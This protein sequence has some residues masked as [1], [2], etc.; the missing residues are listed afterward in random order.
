M[1]GAQHTPGPWLAAE[2]VSS[3]VGLPVVRSG[4]K[5]GRLICNVNCVADPMHGKV[6]GDDAFN[7]EALANAKLIAAAPE[8][9]NALREAERYMIYFSGED[10]TF[11]GPGM[12]ADC[13]RLIRAA[14]SKAVGKTQ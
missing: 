7:R 12:P 1:S 11:V 14:L 4:E 5:G 8:M 9:V 2:A 13:L 3:R 6:A 10:L